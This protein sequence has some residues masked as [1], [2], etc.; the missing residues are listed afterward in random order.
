M[1]A[2]CGNNPYPRGD[3]ESKIRYRFLTSAPKTF[4]PAVS[5]THLSALVMTNVYETLLEYHYLKRPYEL[6]PGLATDV[7]KAEPLPDGRVAYRFSLRPGMLFQ[8]D[9]AFA[10]GA[11][12][13]TTREILAADV[14]FQLMRL[15]DPKVNSPIVATM[16]KLDGFRE[17]AD[18]LTQRR[19][20]EPEFAALRIDRQYAEAGGIRGVQTRG[21]YELLLVLSSP[22]PQILYWFAMSF[23][24]PVP[25]EAVTYYDGA[26]GRPN[27]RDHPVSVGPYKFVQN[28]KHSRIVLA[29]NENWYGALHPEWKAPGAVYPSEGEPEDAERGRLD[30]EY[31]GR[32]LPFIDQIEFRIE[33]ENIPRFNKFFQGYYD[34][35]SIINESFEQIVHEGELSEDMKGRGM[36]LDKAVD[37]DVYYIAFNLDDPVVGTSAHESGRP[38][39]QAM[40]LAVDV[41]EFLRLFTN[42]RGIQ[43]QSVIPPGIFGYDADHRNPYRKLDIPRARELLV[44]AGYPGGIDPKTG[45][46][47]QLNFDTGDTSTRGRLRYQFFVD[48]WSRIGLDVEIHATNYNRFSEKLRDGSYQV[49]LAGWI[50]DYPDPENFLFLLWGE[51]AGSTSGGENRANFR[52]P[53]FDALFLQMKDM[54]NGDA[55][56]AIIREMS[57]IVERERPWIELYHRENYVLYHGWMR[58][59]KMAGLTSSQEKYRDL[60]VE[61]RARDRARWNRPIRWPAYALAGIGFI[62]IV[63]GIVTFLRER[64]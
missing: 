63:P 40:S 59:L 17:F 16:S 35:S 45:R 54:E 57:A 22:Y 61:Q 39:R 24:T 62:A 11:E 28:D 51:N 26:E 20:N 60:D 18:R 41:G 36:D 25:W 34:G 15:A 43:A 12:G 47:L 8:A 52:N 44:E 4:D 14:A 13:R 50:A 10:L 37:P 58:N 6:I 46:P 9:P 2:G 30:P 19:E 38:L 48:S 7:P 31:V 3:D 32:Q 29:R 23:T 5:Y 42:G 49:F 33:K 55:R 56:L 64:Q 1:C 27:F 21:E 53:R